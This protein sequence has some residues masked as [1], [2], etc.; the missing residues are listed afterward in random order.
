MSF[1]PPPPS[2]AKAKGEIETELA[3]HRVVI[4]RARGYIT[5]PV[6]EA[7]FVQFQE[8]AEQISCAPWLIDTLDMTGFHPAAVGVSA[9]WYDVFKERGGSEIV[10]VSSMS[11]V[12][13]AAATLAF[14]VHIKL[15]TFRD[16]PEAYE[17][18]GLGRRSLSPSQYSLKP[19]KTGS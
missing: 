18:A 7:M 11:A 17:H 10:L 2:S 6:C 4:T 14:A 13:M 8:C 1:F 19:P 12:R 16:L 5:G 9:R 15:R 3:D